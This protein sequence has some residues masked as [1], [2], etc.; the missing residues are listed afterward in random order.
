MAVLL[1]DRTAAVSAA[2]SNPWAGGTP[3][4]RR[5]I[6]PDERDHQAGERLGLFHIDAMSGT[7]NGFEPRLA[8]RARVQFAGAARHDAV[9]LA[10]DH[11]GRR[12]DAAEEMRQGRRVHVWLP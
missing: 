4:L 7:G 11:Q 5:L 2:H 10:P 8:Q 6:L 9:V 3:A 12:A 1:C